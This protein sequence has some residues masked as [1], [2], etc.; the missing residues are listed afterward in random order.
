MSYF[1]TGYIVFGLIVLV[2]MN[3]L[4]RRS[5]KTKKHADETVAVAPPEA[6]SNE[7]PLE[8]TSQENELTGR[9]NKKKSKD[10]ARQTDDAVK[11]PYHFKKGPM[12][13]AMLL[14]AFA[15]ILNQTLLNVA[16][17]RIMVDFN[18]SA[19]TVQ[20]LTTAYMLV[21]GVLIPVTAFLMQSIS[22]RKLFL[23]AMICFSAG[24]FVCGVAP[25]FVVL[26]LGRIIQACGAGILIPLMT[27][28][29][30]TIFPVEKRGTAMGTLGIVLMFAPAIGPTLSGWVVQNYSWRVLFFIVLPIAVI[31]IIVAFFLM[32]NV[33]KLTFPKIDLA[34]IFLST[35]GFGA[36]L[37]GFSEAGNNSWSSAQVVVSLVIGVIGILLFIWRELSVKEPML[38]FRVFQYNMFA[39]TTAVRSIA[40]MAMF[41][42]MILVPIYMQTIRGY[43]PL[44][45]GLLLLPGALVMGAFQPIAGR[46]FDKIGAR[47][48]AVVGLAMTV[49]TT[50]EFHNL[51][52]S[53]P[54]SYIMF[55]YGFRMVGMAGIMMPVMTA[56]LNQLPQRL[57]AHGTAMANTM[58]GV[59]SSLGAAFL[60]SVF[61]NRTQFHLG[62]YA[63]EMTSAHMKQQV[64]GLSQHLAAAAGMPSQAANAVTD[65]LLLGAVSKH[66]LIHGMDDAFMIATGLA[67]LAFV[68]SFF[69]RK[70]KPEE[71]REPARNREVEHKKSVAVNER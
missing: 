42:G 22:T 56:G 17:P 66:A 30:M 37:Y 32:R 11:D 2:I 69:I 61:T 21:N 49:W 16:L 18:V 41:A 50:W 64:S 24:T 12:L 52:D 25:N 44:E 1:L 19:S 23:T 15:A 60:V 43:T 47:P 51:T 3:M 28:I 5:R 4:L 38:E 39:L 40:M 53:T 57:T 62:K 36:L 71:E 67:A 8:Q 29:F 27:N 58:R 6:G 20:W 14:G 26:L 33:L 70:T 46:L 34:G 68:L 35:I 59:A 63:N 10:P 48:L 55:L 31:D 45:S 54:Y 7:T 13:T 9:R 65:R